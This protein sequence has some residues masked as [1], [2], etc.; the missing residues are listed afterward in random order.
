MKKLCTF[1]ALLAVLFLYT[2]VSNATG[3]LTEDFNSTAGTLITATTWTAHSGTG[4]NAITVTTTGGAS[5]LSY[6]GYANSNIGLSVTLTTSGEDDNKTLSSSVTSGTLYAAMMINVSSAKTGD[7]FFH[8]GTGTSTFFA[9]LYVKTSGAGYNFGIAKTTETANYETTVRTLGTTYL[10]VLKYTFNTGTTSDDQIALF[11]NPTLASEPTPTLTQTGTAT[12]ATTLSAIYLRQGSTGSAPTVT[13]DGINAG[14]TWGDIIPSTTPGLTATPSSLTGISYIVGSGP[15]VGQ[16][17]SL[18]GVNLTGAPGNI[19]VS[20]STNFEVSLSLGSGYG[21]SVNVPYS[22]STLAATNVYVRLKSGLTV[23]SYGPENIGL[24]GGGATLNVPASGTVEPAQQLNVSTGTITG[25]GYTVGNGPT[26]TPGTYNLSGSNL[27]PSGATITITAPTNFEV[28]LS[29][30]SGYGASVTKTATGSSLA[31][32]PIYVRLVA[33]LGVGSY[34]D[35]VKNSGG[36]APTEKVVVSGTVT[37]PVVT[38][39]TASLNAFSYYL[40]AGPSFEQT[41]TISGS[42]LNPASGSISVT[43]PTDYE[44]STT[45]GTGFGGSLS[46]SYTAGT[47]ASTT[48]YVRLKAGLAIATYNSENIT[49]SGG[50]VSIPNTVC[51]GYVGAA[52]YFTDDFAYA[53]GS[54]LVGQGGWAQTGTVTTN[55]ISITTPGLNG[56]GEAVTLTTGQDANHQFAGVTSGVMYASA[57]IKVTAT[58]T[59]GDYFIHFGD[60]GSFAFYGRTYVKT[61]GAGFVFGFGKTNEAAVYGS[62][63][64]NLNQ[65]YKIVLKYN[66]VAGATNDYLNL[67]INPA[68]GASEPGVADFTSPTTGSDIVDI[69]GINIRQGGSSSAPTVIVDGIKVGQTWAQVNP[70]SGCTLTLKALMEAMFVAGGT[71]MPNPAPVTVQLYDAS[72][73]ALVETKTG[74]LDVNGNGSFLFSS[75]A[76]GT[77]YYIV[78]KSPTTIETWSAAGVS[79]TGG[80]L[81]YDFT[82]ALAQAY[83]DGSLPS[84]S[85]Q[86]GKYCIY[87]GDVNQDGFITNDDFTGVDNDASVGDWHVEND[88]NGDGFVT[89]DDFTFIDNNASVGLAKQVPPGAPAHLVKHTVKNNVQKSTVK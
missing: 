18:T 30:G 82:T 15:S 29:S 57:L 80:A 49:M 86:G 12:D 31:S 85:L 54:A 4:T 69:S 84:M 83:T 53:V 39:S 38:V 59:S 75:A 61:S 7:Y 74:T 71:A 72:T 33:G 50:G 88:V 32:T 19:A 9:R 11:V 8:F 64:Y 58:T 21:A 34:S 41:Y 10:V 73:F 2:G 63:V 13:I 45:T 36:G 25:L 40:G 22:S 79:F 46:L 14:T 43:A 3:L 51:S 55:P 60:A 27:T 68:D 20:G 76:N 37:T 66:F 56:T 42:D 47:L 28:S 62:T 1:M 52:P 17:F 48:I 81:T 44:I 24:S 65:T 35:T 5:G 6:S 77:P 89:N 26:A 87:S 67:Y 23:N 16:S 70:A 78:I